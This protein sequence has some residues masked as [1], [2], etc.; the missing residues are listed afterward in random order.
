M[1]LSGLVIKSFW[2]RRWSANP[3]HQSCYIMLLGRTLDVSRM[4][5]PL[6]AML[7]AF[8][9]FWYGRVCI[10]IYAYNCVYV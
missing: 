10:N 7:L 6:K 3:R 8:G 4:A 2:F 9:I 1:A 5:W